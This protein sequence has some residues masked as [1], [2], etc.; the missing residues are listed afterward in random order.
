[1]VWYTNCTFMYFTS[2]GIVIY[3]SSFSILEDDLPLFLFQ[4]LVRIGLPD[5]FHQK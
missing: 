5:A 2:V 3:F 1:M 4:I